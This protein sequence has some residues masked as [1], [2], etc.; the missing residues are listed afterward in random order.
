MKK[1]L[2]SASPDI[3]QNVLDN[4]TTNFKPLDQCRPTDTV[5]ENGKCC[6]A[7]TTCCIYGS[8][9]KCCGFE[10]VSKDKN[11]KS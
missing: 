8:V 11:L 3:T 2:L 1:L 5:C 9:T 6:A 10:M 7:E 4:S